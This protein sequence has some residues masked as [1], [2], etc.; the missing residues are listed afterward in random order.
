MQMVLVRVNLDRKNLGM[1]PGDA[2]KFFRRLYG[3]HSCSY[4]RRYHHRVDGLLDKIQGKRIANSAI[5]IPKTSFIQL[6]DYLEGNGATAEV[7]SDKIF[8]DEEEFAK[9]D[10]MGNRE[11]TQK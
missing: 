6:R 10:S 3:Y 2:N 7:V 9:I 11:I 5:L 8:M 1:T 4:Y